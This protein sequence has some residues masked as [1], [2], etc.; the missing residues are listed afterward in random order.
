MKFLW[1]GMISLVRRFLFGKLL[2]GADLSLVSD[3][4]N[5]QPAAPANI[6]YRLLTN[7]ILFKENLAV[8]EHWLKQGTFRDG[9]HCFGRIDFIQRLE[10]NQ[11]AVRGWLFHLHARI[12]ELTL[13]L[14]GQR[15]PVQAFALGR[16]DVAACFPYF[17]GA[18]NS[19]FVAMIYHLPEKRVGLTVGFQALLVNGEKVQGSFEATTIEDSPQAE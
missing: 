16:Q 1:W 11:L 12:T 8:L 2:R 14:E 4:L 17:R 18:N 15:Y 19:G 10:S 5:G 3:L 13:I 7:R 9:R 6:R